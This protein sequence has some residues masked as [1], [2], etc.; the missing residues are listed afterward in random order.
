[1]QSH[2]FW[3]LHA[4]LST[5]ISAGLILMASVRMA[6]A[7]LILGALVWVYELTV[8]VSVSCKKYFPR[9]GQELLSVFLASFM[10]SIFLML[11]YFINPPLAMETAFLII[12]TPISCIACGISERTRGMD[13]EDVLGRTLTEALVLGGLII[14]LALIREPWGF[15]SFSVP[16]GQLGITELFSFVNFR[17]FP[18]Q[19]ISSSA[20]GLFLLGYALALFRRFQNQHLGAGNRGIETSQDSKEPLGFTGSAETIDPKGP[21]ESGGIASREENQ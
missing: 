15:G 11:I 8:L 5:L 10:G 2:P 17:F 3:G 20:G 6:Y 12:L 16:G 4:P 13:I 18:V 1:M 19:V 14:A 9:R 21:D 7:L